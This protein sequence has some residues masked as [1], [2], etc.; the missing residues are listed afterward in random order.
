MAFV[1]SFPLPSRIYVNG[2]FWERCSLRS[3]S[4]G[5]LLLSPCRRTK[6]KLSGT[7]RMA[8]RAAVATDEIKQVIED[9]LD[10]GKVTSLTRSGSSGWAVMHRATTESGNHLF[11]KVS[12]DDVQMFE[13]E[14][15]GLQAMYET[16]TIRVP[17]VYHCASLNTLTGSF[18]VMEALNLL[19]IY[20]MSELG[21]KLARL[22]LAEPIAPEARNGQ[23]GF[24]VDNTIGASP[25]PNG[26]MDDWIQFFRDRRLM[27]QALISGDS[28][29]IDKSKQLATKL[30]QLFEDISDSISPSLLHGDLWS[31]NVSGLQGKP[32]LFDPACYYGHHEA[33]FGMSW[34]MS[35]TSAFWEEYRKFIP[36]AEGFDRRLKL[37]QLYH[38]LN[39]YN[40]FGGGYY[41]MAE[42][43]LDELLRSVN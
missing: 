5:T 35:L 10:L 11:I 28:T 17:K 36:K 8:P 33:E 13:G 27:H 14:V 31:G 7:S 41:R 12:R 37:Y 34:C 29:L 40:L 9:S 6:T 2:A 24:D 30:P 4:P 20:D 39:H 22:H 43:L 42:I 16:N 1:G 21:N 18:I 23:F 32:V 26:W 15:A 38:Y 3:V 19:E 25:Q